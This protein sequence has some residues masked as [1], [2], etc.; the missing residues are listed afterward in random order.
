MQTFTIERYR[1]AEIGTGVWKHCGGD[2]VIR[3]FM[4]C[5]N[6]SA[7][8]DQEFLYA[9]ILPQCSC[10][11]ASSRQTRPHHKRYGMKSSYHCMFTSLNAC[12][13]Q[14][15]LGVSSSQFIAYCCCPNLTKLVPAWQ[16]WVKF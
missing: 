2:L 13:K 5:L 6:L 7:Q 16:Y 15:A 4:T 1:K 9:C 14:T 11:N 12:D 3:A 10:L 8:N